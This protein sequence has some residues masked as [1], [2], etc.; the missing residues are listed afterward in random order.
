LTTAGTAAMAR[1]TAG[2]TFWRQGRR[3]PIARRSDVR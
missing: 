3:M 2:I 1:R